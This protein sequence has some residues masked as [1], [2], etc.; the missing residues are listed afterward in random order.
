MGEGAWFMLL[1]TKA[2]GASKETIIRGTV[3]AVLSL[4]IMVITAVS[5]VQKVIQ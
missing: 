5:E 4:L 2:K 3:V 1:E